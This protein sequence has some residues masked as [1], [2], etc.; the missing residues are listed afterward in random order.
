[1]PCAAAKCSAPKTAN[2]RAKQRLARATTLSSAPACTTSFFV[3]NTPITKSTTAAEQ[4]ETTVRE[5]SRKISPKA[6]GGRAGHIFNWTYLTQ[7]LDYTGTVWKR[8]ELV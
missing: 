7:N 8:L 4:V 5:I 2:G 1:M 6:M 3:A